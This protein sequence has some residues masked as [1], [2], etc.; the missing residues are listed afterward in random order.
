MQ[1]KYILSAHVHRTLQ[2]EFDEIDVVQ[3]KDDSLD[4][5]LE[6]ELDIDEPEEAVLEVS[7]EDLHDSDEDEEIVTALEEVEFFLQQGLVED[8]ERVCQELCDRAPDNEKIKDKLLEIEVKKAEEAATPQ[9]E[10]IDLAAEVMAA[11]E[12][13]EDEDIFDLS[14]DSPE[15]HMADEVEI[16]V[17]DAESYYN[18]GIAYKEMGLIDDA[19]AEFDKAM[20]NTCRL[21]DSLALKAICLAETG[22]IDGAEQL[23]WAVLEQPELGAEERVALQYE[24][25]MFYENCNRMSEA[26]AVFEEVIL[27]D[28]NYRDVSAKLP[29]LKAGASVAVP[30]TPK[31]DRVSYI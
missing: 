12:D 23:F 27:T 14:D 18:L 8:A 10:F 11:T 26:I 29:S 9:E 6:I 20:K 2:E 17:E 1:N 4:F 3:L 16:T 31:K 28:S 21:V 25:G 22:D 5:E 7:E 30:S 19:I 13:D 24:L 15:E